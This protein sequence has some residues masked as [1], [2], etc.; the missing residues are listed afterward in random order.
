MELTW[1]HTVA[2]DTLLDEVCSHG[3]GEANHGR[4]GCAVHTSVHH[5][6]SGGKGSTIEG[7]KK[8]SFRKGEQISVPVTIVGFSSRSRAR[9][10]CLWDAV[11]MATGSYLPALR[12][13]FAQS[14]VI[15]QS[16]CGRRV[17]A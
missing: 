12:Q 5:A 16:H 10:Q 13:H 15:R 3:L 14:S 11:P 6:W 1:A 7:I 2:P 9:I 8:V 4:L 17:F